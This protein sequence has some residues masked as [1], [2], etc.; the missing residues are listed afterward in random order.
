MHPH[1]SRAKGIVTVVRR[2][3]GT[4]DISDET[5]QLLRAVSVAVEGNKGVQADADDRVLDAEGV[6]IKCFFH[7]ISSLYLRRST[8][9]PELAAS[10]FDPASMNALARATIE[11]FLV[12]YYVFVAPQ[13]EEERELR[14]LSWRLADLM[15]RQEV[16]TTVPE[17][18]A[19][20]Q[21]ERR[22]I[23][24]IKKRLQNNPEFRKLLPKQKTDLLH[25]KR[26][27]WRTWTEIASDAGFSRLIA[28]H[29]YRYLCSYAHS[30]SLSVMQVTQA[31][32]GADQQELA[33]SALRL[34]NVA[35]AFM[36]KAYCAMFP[37]AYSALANRTELMTK[38]DDWTQLGAET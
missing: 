33:D 17:S 3:G 31:K 8:T 30:G 28:Q 2:F 12:Y 10:F 27:R 7:A 25:K 21:H 6:A 9:V 5:I 19:K 4:M 34:V 38:V 11:S 37:K 15:E 22:I 35:L 23:E 18:M 16:P 32:T 14:H 24:L 20:Q 26:W 36:A 1:N 29:A 13:S